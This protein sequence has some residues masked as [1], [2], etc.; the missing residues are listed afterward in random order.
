MFS[1]GMIPR[2]LG[3]T[4]WTSQA[5]ASLETSSIGGAKRRV[6]AA[7]KVKIF[8]LERVTHEKVRRAGGQRT[9]RIESR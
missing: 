1:S 4:D 3:K 8:R 5:F 6:V 9:M 7:E 2:A